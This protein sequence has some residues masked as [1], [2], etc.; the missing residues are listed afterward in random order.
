MFT[1]QKS[2]NSHYPQSVT[3]SPT[4]KYSTLVTT[5][6]LVTVAEPHCKLANSVDEQLVVFS[7]SYFAL[8]AILTLAMEEPILFASEVL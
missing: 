4:Y 3:E 2:P 5:G 1:V 7:Q 8:T 6:S